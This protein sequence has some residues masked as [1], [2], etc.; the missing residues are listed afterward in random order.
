MAHILGLHGD[1]GKENGNYNIIW[2]FP[3]IRGTLLG[4]PHNKDYVILGFTWGSS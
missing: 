3:K 4:G 2:R 1:N